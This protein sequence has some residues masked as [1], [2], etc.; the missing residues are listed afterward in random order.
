MAGLL[1]LAAGIARPPAPDLRNRAMTA[2]VAL[3]VVVLAEALLGA[4]FEASGL[5]A[6]R[7]PRSLAEQAPGALLLLWLVALPFLRGRR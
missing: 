5:D 3:V 7:A 6:F 1:W 2:A 4:V